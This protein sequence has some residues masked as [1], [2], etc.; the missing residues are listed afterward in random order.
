[1][2]HLLNEH[3]TLPFILSL[4]FFHCVLTEY[5]P[6]WKQQ[7][8]ARKIIQKLSGVLSWLFHAEI[9]GKSG[10]MFS[11]PKRGR[12]R[13]AV[14]TSSSASSGIP[15]KGRGWEVAREEKRRSSAPR[16]EEKRGKFN[17][18]S[19]QIGLGKLKVGDK[20]ASKLPPRIPYSQMS[21]AKRSILVFISIIPNEILKGNYSQEINSCFYLNYL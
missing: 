12:D 9:R 10:F 3:L 8:S 7:E 1:M 15:P 5:F 19:G 17:R 4:C 13:G 21:I 11:L 6:A 20:T 16:E 14:G 2:F 18:N